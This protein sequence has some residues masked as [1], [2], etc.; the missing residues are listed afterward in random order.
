MNKLWFKISS[1]VIAF[2]II[3]GASLALSPK[4]RVSASND[5]LSISVGDNVQ[6]TIKLP[7]ITHLSAGESFAI[8]RKSNNNYE[9]VYDGTASK[10]TIGSGTSTFNNKINF[11]KW[12][13]ESQFY[14]DLPRNLT[15]ALGNAVAT[16]TSLNWEN[17]NYAFTYS[18]VGIKEGFN[19]EGGLD[20]SITV[21][22]KPAVI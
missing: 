17:S 4:M 11:S 12:G 14:L 5:F 19:D 8:N 7:E 22:K 9:I 10:V 1:V 15:G 20:L 21:K 6:E 3:V 16:S 18:P 13:G 2:T